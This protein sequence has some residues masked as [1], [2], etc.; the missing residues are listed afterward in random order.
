MRTS[1]R[2]II[3]LAIVA[4][5]VVLFMAP[6]AQAREH[7]GVVVSVSPGYVYYSSA[8]AY[9]YYYGPSAYYPYP[10]YGYSYPSYSYV[11]PYY[12]YGHFGSG[13]RGGHFRR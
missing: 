3:M 8:P 6:A 5:T 4:G 11:S 1:A 13:H 12:S 9:P 10:Y 2:T 7:R